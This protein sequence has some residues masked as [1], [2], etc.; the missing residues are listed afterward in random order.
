[1]GN[2]LRKERVQKVFCSLFLCG[3]SSHRA[4][5]PA[6]TTSD[7][8]GCRRHHQLVHPEGETGGGQGGTSAGTGPRHGS[9]TSHHWG[10]Q[11]GGAGQG[12]RQPQGEVGKPRGRER[13]K[14]G[15]EKRGERSQKI[16]GERNEAPSSKTLFTPEGEKIIPRTTEERPGICQP[17]YSGQGSQ[18]AAGGMRRLSQI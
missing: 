8:H 7:F 17:G 15:I 11:T 5:W 6:L 13:R 4:F 18:N 2:L 16:R 3:Q 14:K 1:M 9:G 12:P 10:R